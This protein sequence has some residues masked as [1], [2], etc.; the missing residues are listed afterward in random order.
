MLL[1]IKS[2][3]IFPFNK[4]KM[5]TLKKHYPLVLYAA[6]CLSSMIYN[7]FMLCD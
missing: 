3:D 7:C 4:K 5:L 1:I 6:I 2:I